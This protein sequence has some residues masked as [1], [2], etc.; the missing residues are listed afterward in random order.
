MCSQSVKFNNNKNNKQINKHT[1]KTT[2]VRSCLMDE[3]EIFRASSYGSKF[4]SPDDGNQ[5][6]KQLLSQH[7]FDD[8]SSTPVMTSS[9]TNVHVADNEDRVGVLDD[10]HIPPGRVTTN[11]SLSDDLFHHENSKN[12]KGRHRRTARQA[13]GSG[14]LQG[15]SDRGSAA[16]KA[17][18][19]PQ[20]RVVIEPPS[21]TGTSVGDPSHRRTR[22]LRSR[23][24]SPAEVSHNE[25]N[26]LEKNRRD[27]RVLNRAVTSP[28]F[29][30]SVVPRKTNRV[31][32]ESSISTP[33]PCD[34]KR[35][36]QSLFFRKLH[37]MKYTECHVRCV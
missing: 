29:T 24:K 19:G 34:T 15:N 14:R 3:F 2:T 25:N 35:Y 9:L 11:K 13:S 10:L 7:S 5:T 36:S 8:V 12:L 23:S 6:D 4:T 20:V 28:H 1:H 30:S 27:A 21:P 17:C 31:D 18:L 16:R 26:L 37:N 22:S 32:Y 33:L